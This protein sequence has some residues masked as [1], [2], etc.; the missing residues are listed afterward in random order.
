[1]S[2][3]I[4]GGQLGE[5]TQDGKVAVSQYDLWCDR[6]PQPMQMKQVIVEDEDGTTVYAKS[7]PKCFQYFKE[8]EIKKDQKI[9]ERNE[10]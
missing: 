3:V 5:V 10:N 2:A 4:K 6:H 1:M 9:Q 7:C 8:G